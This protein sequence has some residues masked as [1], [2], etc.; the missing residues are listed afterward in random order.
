[1][2]SKLNPVDGYALPEPPRLA[3]PRYYRITRSSTWK[4]RDQPLEAER[5]R[6]P[7]LA[8]GLLGELLYGDQPRIIDDLQRR[9]RR[10]GP[11]LPRRH[12]LA[13]GHPA[14]RPGASA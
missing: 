12:A 1:M 10:P 8:G 6:L 2:T 4:E 9:R 14:L 5:D 3:S 13:D 7:L 11:R